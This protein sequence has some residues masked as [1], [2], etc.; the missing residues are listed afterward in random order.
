MF[1]SREPLPRTAEVVIIGGGVNGC[2]LAYHLAKKGVRNVVLLEKGYLASGG[3][4][5]SAAGIRHQFGTEI[6]IRL[7][8]ASIRLLEGLQEETGYPGDLELRQGGY[9]M[10]AYTESQGTQLKKNIALQ[11]SLGITSRYVSPE[12]IRAIVPA[13]NL[14][15]V[16]GASFYEKDGHA[17]PFHVTFAYA[18]AAARRGVKI[19]TYTE[20]TGIKLRG[21]EK[22]TA[23]VADSPRK[24]GIQAGDGGWAGY[25]RNGDLPRLGDR[26]R[27]VMEVV[28][29]SGN[30]AT[31][32]VVNVAGA[33]G[34]LIGRM[35]GLE[36]PITAERHQILVTEPVEPLL[37]PMIISFDYGTYCKQE[38][39]GGIVMGVGDPEELKGFGVHSSWQFLQEVSAKVTN[40]LPVLKKVRL[41]RQWAG[42]YDITPDSQPILGEAPGIKGFYNIV[43]FSGHGFMLGPI[44]GQLMAD[45][46]VEEE[47][48]IP[49]HR[50]LDLGRFARGE[51]VKEPA[52][53]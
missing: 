8:T 43:G 28:T 13:M 11:N 40:L 6:N 19:F 47:P 49:V 12:E 29:P 10:V 48:A 32:T 39:H 16:R 31:R 35:V 26:P 24:K 22:D 46:I 44:I 34:L 3:T 33:H 27:E 2:S 37:R 36:L 51:L 7:S 25:I 9:L 21:G 38:P 4:G 14:A 15:G 20:V 53:V 41:V 5:R 23:V 17:N 50:V 42:L 45:L 1:T 30:I 18:E 52:V